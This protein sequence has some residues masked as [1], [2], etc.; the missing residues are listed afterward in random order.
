MQ[1]KGQFMLLTLA[2][3]ISNLRAYT[4]LL[5]AEYYKSIYMSRDEL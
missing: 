5:L 4:G 3:M 2:Y 1:N